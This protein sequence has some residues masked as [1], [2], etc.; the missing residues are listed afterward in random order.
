MLDFSAQVARRERSPRDWEGEGD[1]AAGG[2]R[3]LRGLDRRYGDARA[4][5]RLQRAGVNGQ[6]SGASLDRD[7]FFVASTVMCGGRRCDR[8]GEGDD[9]DDRP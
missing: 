5:E 9:H 3:D 8:A 1:L 4:A 7:G 2:L 6:Q